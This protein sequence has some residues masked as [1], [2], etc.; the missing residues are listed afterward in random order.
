M[1][2]FQGG[3]D[4]QS[5]LERTHTNVTPPDN[6]TTMRPANAPLHIFLSI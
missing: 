6:P 3:G 4:K 5:K 2:E 1:C